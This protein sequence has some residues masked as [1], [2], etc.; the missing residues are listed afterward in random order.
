VKPSELFIV[1]LVYIVVVTLAYAILAALGVGD[2]NLALAMGAILGTQ[3]GAWLYH[4]REP[5]AA[6]F[7]VKATV[8]LLMAV[9]CVAQSLLFQTLWGWLK[10][11]EVS[12]PIGAVGTFAV[13]FVLYGTMQKALVKAKASGRDE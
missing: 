5:A 3:I 10:Y 9:L 8:G 12:V 4:R 13:P 7:S 2:M 6:P 11:P 1:G